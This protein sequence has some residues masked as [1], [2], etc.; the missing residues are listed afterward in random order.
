M[1]NIIYFLF[2]KITVSC[3]LNINKKSNN[4]SEN[5]F[6][7]NILQAS[8]LFYIYFEFSQFLNPL[9]PLIC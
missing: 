1:L 4:K 7:N 9:I 3:D 2:F 6:K 5:N 8:K